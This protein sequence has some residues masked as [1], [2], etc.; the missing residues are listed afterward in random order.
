MGR[1]I[2]K[3]YMKI[4]YL[5]VFI[6]DQERMTILLEDFLTHTFY[7]Y[8]NKMIRYIPEHTR[9]ELQC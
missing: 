6:T 9:W 8:V 5:V 4:L 2:S 3:I 1:F 7:T